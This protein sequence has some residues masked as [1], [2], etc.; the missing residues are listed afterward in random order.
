MTLD[1]ATKQ[2]E[3]KFK[4]VRT[5]AEHSKDIPMVWSGGITIPSETYPPVLYT[6]Q[7][8]AISQ[9]RTW[10][11]AAWNEKYDHFEGPP[12]LEWVQ[13]PELVEYMITIADKRGM[14]RAVSNRWAVKSQFQVI[15]G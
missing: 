11:F 12:I 10:A 9:W 15:N 14:H 13:K 6:D 4:T 3:A 1:D 8:Y 7:E 5:R 2:Y